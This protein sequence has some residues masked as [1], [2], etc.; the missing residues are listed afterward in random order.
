MVKQSAP[1][2]NYRTQAFLQ[3]GLLAGILLF[4]NI[5]ASFVFTRFDL[6]DDKRFTLTEQSKNL[7]GGLKDVVYI[8]VYLEGDFSPGFSKL[9]N[10]TKELLDELRIYSKGNLEY[11]FIDPS[12]HPG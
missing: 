5:I 4:A 10:A 2:K 8:K 12:A 9:R 3:M 11:E 1:V 7:V 6:T